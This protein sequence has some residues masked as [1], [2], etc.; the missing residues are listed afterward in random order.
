MAGEGEQRGWNAGALLE[1]SLELP[2][3]KLEHRPDPRV[4]RVGGRR[5]RRHLAATLSMTSL[6]SRVG[7]IRRGEWDLAQVQTIAANDK[8][9]ECKG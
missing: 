6:G 4:G 7:R 8:S 3:R 5:L 9:P 1:R 2:R